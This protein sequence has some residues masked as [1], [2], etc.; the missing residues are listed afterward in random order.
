MKV[1]FVVEPGM[2]DTLER[3]RVCAKLAMTHIFIEAHVDSYIP[4]I[5]GKKSSSEYVLHCFLWCV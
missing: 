3:T 4:A 2:M 1:V 5:C